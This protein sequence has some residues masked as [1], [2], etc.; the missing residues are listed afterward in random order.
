MNLK[1]GTGSYVTVAAL[2]VPG[3]FLRAYV[4]A[5]LWRWFAVPAGLPVI[6]MSHAY[7]LA[8]LAQFAL[9]A[10][11]VK[12]ADVA[13]LSVSREATSKERSSYVMTWIAK[14]LI[15][16]LLTLGIGYVARQLMAF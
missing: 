5:A 8:L 4:L 2:M 7:G 3:F 16:P 12:D 6:G 15:I 9:V 1:Y 11:P 13:A 10:S 14:M